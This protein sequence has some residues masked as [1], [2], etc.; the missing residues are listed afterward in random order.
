MPDAEA[1]L[2]EHEVDAIMLSGS[3]AEDCRWLVAKANGVP[4]IALCRHPDTRESFLQ[5]GA[6]LTYVRESLMAQYADVVTDA[7]KARGRPI[8]RPFEPPSRWRRMFG[9]PRLRWAG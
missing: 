7:A 8:R 1:H 6:R 9:L 5:A 3:D 4:V 2:I